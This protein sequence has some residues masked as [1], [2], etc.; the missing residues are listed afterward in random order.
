[1]TDLQASRPYPKPLAP[2]ARIFASHYMALQIGGYEFNGPY[3]DWTSL[4]EE[5]GVIVV[6]G[7]NGVG[8]WHVV[9]IDESDNLRR[10]V[11]GH[12][13]MPK[14]RACNHLMLV[15]AA[16]YVTAPER[17]IIEQELRAQYNPPCGGR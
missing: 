4:L 6:L 8:E 14:W 15:V 2:P 3:R 13:R 10:R 5:S 12:E 17:M 11:E 1:M 9:D 7:G 16:L